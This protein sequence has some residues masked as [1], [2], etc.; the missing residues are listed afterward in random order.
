MIINTNAINVLDAHADLLYMDQIVSSSL[1]YW[2]H[3]KFG[4]TTS[5][6]LIY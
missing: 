2:H 5:V 6:L 3:S 4:S 1:P